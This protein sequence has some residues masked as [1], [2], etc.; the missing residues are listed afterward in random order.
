MIWLHL[1]S[2]VTWITTCLRTKLQETFWPL[3][4]HSVQ[5]SLSTPPISPLILSLSILDPLGGRGVSPQLA[6]LSITLTN[7]YSDIPSKR[8]T[9]KAFASSFIQL[10][11]NVTKLPFSLFFSFSHNQLAP[12]GFNKG[13][14]CLFL[15]QCCISWAAKELKAVITSSKIQGAVR[16]YIY[17]FTF[18]NQKYNLNI[19]NYSELFQLLFTSSFPLIAHK[20]SKYISLFKLK[21]IKSSD[22]HSLHPVGRLVCVTADLK[23]ELCCWFMSYWIKLL[24]SLRRNLCHL[25]IL[26]FELGPN[27]QTERRLW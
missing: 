8:R 17:I 3:L 19:T 20:Y 2:A 10:W 25:R 22:S 24:I 4:L 9:A 7:F 26:G 16:K 27:T 23:L 1:P 6:L 12:K 5:S 21:S 13:L 15:W 11:R 18:L 14:T